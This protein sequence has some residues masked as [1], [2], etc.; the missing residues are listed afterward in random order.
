[1]VGDGYNWICDRCGQY[2]HQS[3]QCSQYNRPLTISEL[4][5]LWIDDFPNTRTI[6]CT[7]GDVPKGWQCPEC[8]TVYSPD[9]GSCDCNQDVEN[10]T[11]KTLRFV[12]IKCNDGYF[13]IDIETHEEYNL[14]KFDPTYNPKALMQIVDL[15]NSLAEPS[16]NMNEPP[17]QYE[18]IRNNDQLTVRD[19]FI[20]N[21]YTEYP[22]TPETIIRLLEQ[23]NELS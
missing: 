14:S 7:W 18:V 20:A 13:I 5:S 12:Y 22:V 19:N 2:G 15:L 3:W 16:E 23:I 17:I 6:T 10:E 8:K 11:E 1:M 9:V 21:T 4:N